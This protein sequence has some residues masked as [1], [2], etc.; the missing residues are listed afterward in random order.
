MVVLRPDAAAVTKLIKA[1][2]A[3][4]FDLKTYTVNGNQ[5]FAVLMLGDT[6]NS[7]QSA[8]ASCDTNVVGG[9]HSTLP[10]VGLGLPSATTPYD[11]TFT[12]LMNKYKVP[13]GAARSSRTASW[14]SPEATV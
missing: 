4:I 9:W 8:D 13:G 7:T 14:C 11:S 1:N 12:T 3:R 10:A 6:W 5:V 2:A